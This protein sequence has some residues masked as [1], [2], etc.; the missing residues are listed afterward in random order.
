M[1]AAKKRKPKS[2]GVRLH[3]DVAEAF[4]V[5]MADVRAQVGQFGTVSENQVVAILI[6]EEVKRRKIR[7]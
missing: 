2:L 5:L 1:A 3:P 7:K 4:E 6:V